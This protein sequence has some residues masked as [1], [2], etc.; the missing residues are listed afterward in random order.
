MRAGAP[1]SIPASIQD[2]GDDEGAIHVA[3]RHTIT[4]M[5]HQTRVARGRDLEIV[6]HMQH[7]GPIDFDAC[8]KKMKDP[9]RER[10]KEVWELFLRRPPKG[11]AIEWSKHTI[12]K[13]DAGLTC[14]ADNAELVTKEMELEFPTEEAIRMFTTIEER[15]EQERRRLIGWTQADNARLKDQYKARVPIHHV[16]YYLDAVKHPCGGK[17]DL[18]CGFYGMVVPR[19]RRAKFRF[20][21]EEGTLYQMKVATMGHCTTPELMHTLTATIGGHPDYVKPEFVIPVPVLHVFIDGLRPA[22]KKEEVEAY[23]KQ[24]DERAHEVGA[25]WKEK[26]SYCGPIYTF[27]GVSFDHNVG[28]VAVGNKLVK[29]IKAANTSETTLG[30]LESLVAR[31]NHA[32]AIVQ[33]VIPD[34]YHAIKYVRRRTSQ[35]NRGVDPRTPITVSPRI[36]YLLDV[37]VLRCTVKGFVKPPPHPLH[38]TKR[39][40]TM[41][42][43]SSKDG[44]GAVLI[45]NVTGQIWIA[46]ARWPKNH[47]FEINKDE[48]AAV[49]HSIDAFAPLIVP[50]SIIDL[51]IDN[52]SAEA[53]TKKGRSQS[54]GMSLALGAYI[55]TKRALDIELVPSRVSSKDNWSD[56][57]SR[58]LSR[59]WR[60]GCCETGGR[61]N[62]VFTPF[63]HDVEVVNPLAPKGSTS[64]PLEH[65][66]KHGDSVSLR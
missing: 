61:G 56:P 3:V 55:R 50:G 24:V 13:K 17:R 15:D 39:A 51:R 33:A 32:S 11:T 45:C 35:L 43:D 52:T 26:D 14:D 41:F 27:D 48:T 58:G 57:I 6:L 66:N 62:S 59:M 19:E 4:H 23:L 21:D 18:L 38:T 34:F 29:K 20:R 65:T 40:F 16:S 44:H 60:K 54:E 46:G 2:D 42:T 28:G 10:Q 64:F 7:T 30:D 25:L 12:T 22:G 1:I 9:V 49:T 47:D 8:L 53:G 31:L 37:W 5:R 36:S 63:G